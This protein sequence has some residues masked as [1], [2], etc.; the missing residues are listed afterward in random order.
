MNTIKHLRKQNQWLGEYRGIHFKIVNWSFESSQDE[1]TK[2]NYYLYLP[3]NRCV[4]FKLLW[5]E[6]KPQKFCETSPVRIVH[7][8]YEGPTGQINMHGGITWY[9]KLGHTEGHRRIE[10]GCDFMH[11]YDDEK[12]WTLEDMLHDIITAVDGLY[13]DNILKA[14]ESITSSAAS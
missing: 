3:E 5:H 8:Y 6:D 7:D 2:W 11:L 4:D 1:M 10:V 14:N 12:T 9:E 13:N